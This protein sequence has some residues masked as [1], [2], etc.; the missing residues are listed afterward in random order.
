MRFTFGSKKDLCHLVFVTLSA[1]LRAYFPTETDTGMPARKWLCTW[2]VTS[3]TIAQLPAQFRAYM[4]PATPDAF[5]FT[6]ITRITTFHCALAVLAVVA[7]VFVAG[8][9]VFGA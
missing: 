5:L 6:R 1:L 3:W 9:T 7:T 2:N 4:M 8:R